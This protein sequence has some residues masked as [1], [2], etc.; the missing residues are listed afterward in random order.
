[1]RLENPSP[2]IVDAVNSAMLWLDK[3]KIEGKKMTTITDYSLE[4]VSNRILV[5][6]PNSTIW[7][8]FYEINSDFKPVFSG[9]D[10][11]VKYSMEEISYE[12]RNKY[13]WYGSYLNDKVS[14]QYL[15]RLKTIN[16]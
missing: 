2:E 16:K 15:E 8:R 14:A 4:F 9:R 6:D 11:V 12:R 5:D 10:S 3:V 1:M 13:S 7:A